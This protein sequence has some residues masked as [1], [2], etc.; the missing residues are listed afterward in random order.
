MKISEPT[1]LW[2]CV[3]IPALLITGAVRAEGLLAVDNPAT[4]GETTGVYASVEAFQANDTLAIRQYLGDWQGEYSPRAGTNTGLLAA[5]TEMGAQW[6]GF[7]LGALYRA[8]ARVETNRDTSD[9][10]RQYNTNSGYDAGRTYALD[11]KSAGFAA[12]GLRVGKSL[13]LQAGKE[14]TVRLGVAAALLEGKQLKVETSAGSVVT[15]NAKDFSAIAN[16]LSSNS[17]LDINDPTLFN[18]FVRPQQAFG[19]QGYAVDAGLVLR[20]ADGL[21]V[22]A[23]VNDLAGRIDWKNVPQRFTSYN[24][25][26][27]YY[28][29]QGYA[30][31]N[32]TASANSSFVN[33]AQ[34][35]DP[36]FW[37]AVSYPLGAYEVQIATSYSANLWLPEVNVKIPLAAD[38]HLKAGYDTH[39][40][41][42]LLGLQHQWFECSL[43]SDNLDLTRAKGYGLSLALTVPI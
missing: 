43:R 9:V 3:F 26:N 25:A 4:N 10:V 31:F 28:D 22:E 27:K 36:R 29:A 20:R 17:S 15:L 35:L 1:R 42:V 19:G 8:Q 38:W 14:W 23:A 40:A 41:T 13:A 11:Y 32:A 18:P 30:R 21:Q 7:R 34:D 37:L 24:T 12:N 16:T 39:F 33:Y 2:A 5:R 6:N